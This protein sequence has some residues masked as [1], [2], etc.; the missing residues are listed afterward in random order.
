MPALSRNACLMDNLNPLLPLFSFSGAVGKMRKVGSAG[1]FADSLAVFAA[2]KRIGL[3]SHIRL[4]GALVKLSSITSSDV[5]TYLQPLSQLSRQN[6]I[7][8]QKFHTGRKRSAL[9]IVYYRLWSARQK[10]V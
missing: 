6:E 3:R 5:S 10:S 1:D 4:S 9:D 2:P 7:H 8:N